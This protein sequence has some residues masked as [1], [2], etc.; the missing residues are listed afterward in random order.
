MTSIYEAGLNRFPILMRVNPRLSEVSVGSCVQAHLNM[1]I[2]AATNTT[3]DCTPIPPTIVVRAPIR[4][5][6][7]AGCEIAHSNPHAS[8]HQQV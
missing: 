2:S 7:G 4:F 1:G 6:E 5:P 3:E 8:W